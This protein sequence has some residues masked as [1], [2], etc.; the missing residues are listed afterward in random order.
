[1]SPAGSQAVIKQGQKIFS[2]I[3]TEPKITAG[4]REAAET[5]QMQNTGS[6][7]PPERL[8]WEKNNGPPFA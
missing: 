4:N 3:A 2:P 6:R 1:M 8:T 7:S 5:R